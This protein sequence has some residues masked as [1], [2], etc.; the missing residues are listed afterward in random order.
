MWYNL[1]IACVYL[2]HEYSLQSLLG[3]CTILKTVYMRN[4]LVCTFTYDVHLSSTLP[5]N[6]S[7]CTI[8]VN[9]VYV[10]RLGVRSVKGKN[11]D[12]SQN[13]HI[14]NDRD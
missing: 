9:T 14:H 7:F 8:Q 1:S 5:I 13:L 4:L 12:T 10:E 6:K 11:L 2:L 3:L